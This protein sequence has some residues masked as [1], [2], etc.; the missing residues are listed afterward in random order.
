MKSLSY[1]LTILLLISCKKNK[2]EE[3]QPNGSKIDNEASQGGVKLGYSYAKG[4]WHQLSTTEL[5]GDLHLS[6]KDIYLYSIE[7]SLQYHSYFRRYNQASNTWQE[8]YKI[9]NPKGERIS[10]DAKDNVY[11]L[12]TDLRTEGS[13]FNMKYYYN[14][15]VQQLKSNDQWES[16]TDVPNPSQKDFTEIDLKFVGGKLHFIGIRDNKLT[17]IS[18]HNGTWS[19]TASINEVINSGKYFAHQNSDGEF[20]F[21]IGIQ[22]P[23]NTYI[24]YKFDGSSI[25][26]INTSILNHE[27]VT[28]GADGFYA[29]DKPDAKLIDITRQKEIFHLT[30]FKANGELYN[31]RVNSILPQSSLRSSNQYIYA[32]VQNYVIPEWL[33]EVL[34]V[35]NTQTGKTMWFPNTPNYNS[36][37]I[38]NSVVN[39]G[40]RHYFALQKQLIYISQK[41]I[42]YFEEE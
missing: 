5:T 12:I 7:G 14:Y 32:Q 21:A 3:Q 40:K 27:L 42:Y 11:M 35:H 19:E 36:K 37:A 41:H 6:S 20:I 16:L 24:T 28:F 33:N 8:L 4:K 9:V 25:Q 17:I 29:S 13:G 26:L 31:R 23:K 30:A 15:K 22:S 1:L 38:I 2:I 18:L 34:A 10:I 39:R